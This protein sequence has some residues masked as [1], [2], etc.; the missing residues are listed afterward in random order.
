LPRI[1]SAA[2]D[3]RLCEPFERTGL[4][5]AGIDLSVFHGVPAV[6]GV[7]RA[8]AG[9]LG[10]VGVGAAAAPTVERAWWK[11]LSEA[12]AVR[13]ASAKLALLAGATPLDRVETFD[14]HILYYAGHERALATAFL[15]ASAERIAPVDVP[16]LEAEAPAESIA[17]LCGRVEA[18][19]SSAY[20]VDVTSPDVAQ[21][22]LRVTRV[23]APELCA[24]D[25]SHSARF[26]GGR[27]LYEAAARLGLR[28]EALREDDSNPDPHPF[29]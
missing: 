26:L 19:G 8:P 10:A 20:A 7:V 4:A 24:L 6:L 21:L 18:A 29:P 23:I 16:K 11:A 13:A 15:D 9:F 12:F 5:H 28:P 22:D 27:R 3:R 25:A 2:I 17:A 14:D 1:D